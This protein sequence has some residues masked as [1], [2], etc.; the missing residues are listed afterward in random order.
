MERNNSLTTIRKYL[1]NCDVNGVVNAIKESYII[2]DDIFP[3]IVSQLNNCVKVD[4][5]QVF[6]CSEVALKTIAEL[7]DPEDILL[8]IIEDIKSAVD[9]TA[10]LTLT[11]V[12]LILLRRLPK[13]RLCSLGW[14]LNAVSYY[15]SNVTVLDDC[16]K[17]DVDRITSLC[18]A[19]CSFYKGVVD[20]LS[21]SYEETFITL[22]FAMQL[23]GKPLAFLDFASEC[24]ARQVSGEVV[25]LLFEIDCDIFSLL[26]L[27]P[28]YDIGEIDILALATLF[29]LVLAERIMLDKMPQV[30]SNVYMF[31]QSVHLITHLLKYEEFTLLHGLSLLQS[32][33][34]RLVGCILS[35][36]LLDSKYHSEFCKALTD[37]IVY[38]Q[39]KCIR[40][41]ALKLYRRYI[42]LFDSRGR[43]LLMYN[44]MK[45]LHHSGII[46]YTITQCK[47]MVAETL[48]KTELSPYFSGYNLICLLRQFCFLQNYEEAHLLDKSEQI[49]AFLNL[50][51]FLAIRDKENVT[52]IYNYFKLLHEQFL[53]PLKKGV[54]LSRELQKVK[55]QHPSIMDP[56]VAVTVEGKHLPNLSQ[57]EKLKS[58]ELSIV[59]FDMIDN[60]LSHLY[61]IINL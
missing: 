7:Y 43:Y 60:L 54:T 13:K 56:E 45:I 4:N 53:D 51:R 50:L 17:S 57:D 55:I 61:E 14:G 12:L 24:A 9:D 47:D 58:L 31:Q 19:L 23:L 52:G 32:V 1:T 48:N 11:F 22:K 59:T 10:F 16:L 40:Q 35:S 39:D 46:G 6:Q 27:D 38:N 2:V 44:L 36:Y 21:T 25:A 33:V 18:S 41:R 5:L 8:L 20:N 42:F 37:V 15:Y 26:H 28:L 29:Y 30:Y 49:L 34:N 3:I